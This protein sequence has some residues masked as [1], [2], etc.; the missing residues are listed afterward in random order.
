MSTGQASSSERPP[1]GHGRGTG[2][3]S[4][5]KVDKN[6]PSYRIALQ[7]AGVFVI[8]DPFDQLPETLHP[9]LK[10]LFT[11]VACIPRSCIRFQ[12]RIKKYYTDVLAALLTISTASARIS[13]SPRTPTA[14]SAARTRPTPSPHKSKPGTGMSFDGGSSHFHTGDFNDMNDDMIDQIT[15]LTEGTEGDRNKSSDSLGWVL[16]WLNRLNNELPG[17]FSQVPPFRRWVC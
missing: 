13:N 1:S 12:T 9:A 15:A 8:D 5:A 7:C 14:S 2:E 4:H 10:D 3:T 11:P 6:S 16:Y 17:T